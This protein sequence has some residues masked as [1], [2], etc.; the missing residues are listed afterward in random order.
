MNKELIEALDSFQ[1]VREQLDVGLFVSALFASLL[2]AIF[3]SLLYRFFY[4]R[5]GTGSQVHRAFPLLAISITTL[6]IG[7]QISIPLSLGL[8]GALS[9]IRFRT[10]IK[11]PEEVGFIMLVIASSIAAATFNFAFLFLLNVFAIITLIC[12]RG[13]TSIKWLKRDGMMVIIFET[14]EATEKYKL[15]EEVIKENLGRY[16][17]ESTAVRNGQTSY[18]YV[19]SN[20]K[21]SVDELQNKLMKKA[22]FIAI[23][24]YLDKPGGIR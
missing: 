8:L 22:K 21:C 9:I 6:F 15:V 24:V 18:Q 11:E 20:L 4:E 10:P 16:Q 13:T 17:L 14:P 7:V 2:A 19:F 23:N 3:A 1:V 5:R 12:M